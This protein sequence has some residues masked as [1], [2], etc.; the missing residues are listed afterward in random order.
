MSQ[1]LTPA[2]RRADALALVAETAL[3]G[4]L[5]AGTAGDRYQ[6]VVHVTTAEPAADTAV[7]HGRVRPAR[8][9][10]ALV[11]GVLE[12]EHG[13]VDVSMETSQRV[14]CDASERDGTAAG[15]G[16]GRRSRASTGFV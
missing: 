15:R 3:A 5:D 8:N 6:V 10:A 11:D 12:V 7:P 16:R 14:A 9:V 1:E 4:D 13:A 2:Q